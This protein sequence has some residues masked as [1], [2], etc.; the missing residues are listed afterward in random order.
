[1][2][3]FLPSLN[4]PASGMTSN[5]RRMDTIAEN[6]V[7]RETTRTDDG[8]PFRRRVSVFQEISG[9]DRNGFARILGHSRSR[10]VQELINNQPHGGVKLIQTIEDPTDFIPVFD[11]RHP[12]ANEEGY[13]MM[14]N[15]NN[16]IEMVDAMAASRSYSSNIAAFE[17]IRNMAQ[18]AL[19]LGRR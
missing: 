7:N 6:I 5:M 18:Q 2:S 9:Q 1:M 14:P 10:R 3:N 19:E 15:V 11:P 12:D 4:I 8:G 16:T 17:A 13:V